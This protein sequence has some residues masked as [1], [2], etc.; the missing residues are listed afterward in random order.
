[1]GNSSEHFSSGIVC[2]SIIIHIVDF[3]RSDFI[4]SLYIMKAR[5]SLIEE[6]HGNSAHSRSYTIP[7]SV[8]DDVV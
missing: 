7:K 1:M 5:E 6:G 3:P 2:T 8:N 4:Y